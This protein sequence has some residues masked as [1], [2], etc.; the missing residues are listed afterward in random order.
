MKMQLEEKPKSLVIRLGWF[1][2][3]WLASVVALGI[4]AMGIR[5]AIR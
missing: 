2:G 3:F 4:V 5:W 1:A